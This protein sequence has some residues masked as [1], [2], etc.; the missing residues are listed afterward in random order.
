MRIKYFALIMLFVFSST[1]P[2]FYCKLLVDAVKHP[3]Q[4]TEAILD[5]LAIQPAYKTPILFVSACFTIALLPCAFIECP[6]LTPLVG[7]A[8]MAGLATIIGTTAHELRKFKVQTLGNQLLHSTQQGDLA[9]IKRLLNKGANPN[10]YANETRI[11]AL[12]RAAIESFLDII[13]LLLERGADINARSQDGNTPLHLAASVQNK[14]I[15]FQLLARGADKTAKNIFGN[16]PT[17]YGDADIKDLMELKDIY[18]TL[19][20]REL[21]QKVRFK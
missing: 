6:N 4:S 15:V 18:R 17:Y 10:Y 7:T 1:K 8:G 21:G 19:K 14:E 2:M 9:A 16:T 20:K 3:R 11:T 12:H 13:H 5:Y